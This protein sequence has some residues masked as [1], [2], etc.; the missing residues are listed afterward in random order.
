LSSAPQF[1]S[2][3]RPHGPRAVVRAPRGSRAGWKTLLAWIAGGLAALVF[4]VCLTVYVALHSRGVHRYVLRVSQEKATR[5]LGVKVS[6][7]D[8]GLHFSGISPVL[9]LYSLSIEG[10]PPLTSPPLAE[11]QRLHVAITVTSLLHRNWYV[12]DIDLERPVIRVQV[13]KNGNNNL[14]KPKT[15]N[16]KSSTN[17]FDLGVRHARIENGE[18]YYN[19]RKAVLSADLH[20]LNFAS[21]YDAALRT[22]SGTLGYRDGRLIVQNYAPVAHQLDAEFVAS[23]Q[24]FTLKQAALRSGNSKLLL[25]AV[26][27]D[28]SSPRI[29]AQYGVNLD[30]GEASRILR[31]DSLPRGLIRA[32]GKIN[33]ITAANRPFL[34]SIYVDGNLG[35]RQLVIQAGSVHQA[36]DDL[37]ASY[38]VENGNL[39][40]PDLRAHLLGGNLTASLV[41]RDL[42]GNSR[43]HLTAAL[44]N[45]SLKSAQ[46]LKNTQE[47]R[48]LGLSGV[49]N[50]TADAAWGKT[51]DDLVARG[52]AIIR[53]RIA[54]SSQA[55]PVPLDGAV[56]ARYDAR[57]KQIDMANSFLRTPETSLTL[58]G[59]VSSRSALQLVLEANDLHELETIA[60]AIRP[61][62]P[63]IGLYGRASMHATVTGTTDAPK[64]DSQFNATNLKVRGT[65]WRQLRANIQLDPSQINLQ[66]GELEAVNH[67]RVSFGLNAKLQK[68]SFTDTSPV[69]LSLNAVHIDMGDIMRGAGKQFPLSGT[70]AAAI[71]LHGS[72]QSPLGNGKITLTNAK[73]QDEV[74][75]SLS[76]EFNGSGDALVANLDAQIPAGGA[77]AKL[78]LRPRQKYFEGQLR[79]DGIHLD[80]LENVKQRN[81]PLRGVLNLNADGKG[82]FDNPGLNATLEVPQLDVRG[83]KISGLKLQTSVANHIG[84]FDLRS[85]VVHTSISSHG[86]VRLTDDFYADAK[87]DTQVIP[88]EP[89]VEAYAASQAGNI[90]GQ[91]EL[92]ATIRGPLKKKDQLEAHVTIPQLSVNYKDSIRIAAAGPIH[93]DSVRGTLEIPRGALRGTGTDLQFQGTVPLATNAAASILLQGSVDLNLAQIFDPDLASSGQIKFDINSYGRRSDPNVHGEI[94]VVNANFATGTVPLGL[95]GGNGVLTLLTDRVQISQFKGVLGGGNFTASGAV[96]YRPALHFDVALSGQDTRVLYNNIRGAFNSKLTLSGNMDAAQLSGRV[97]VEQMQ[98][99]PAF[100]LTDFMGDLGGGATTPPPIGGFQQALQLNVG[101]NST[102]GVNLVSRTMSLQAAANLRLTGTAAQPV[103]LGRVN[104][105]GGDLIFRGN[106]YV[107]QG[108]TLDFVN[109]SQTMPVV[110]LSANTTVQQY[111]VQMRFWG[112]IDHLHTNYSSD[113]A[114]PP[115]DII[116]LIAVGKTLEARGAEPSPPGNLAAEQF[117]ASQVSSQ[118]T[119]RLEKVSGLSQLSVDPLLGSNRAQSPGARITVQERVTGKIFVTFSTDTTSTQNSVMKIE[120]HETPRVSYS[121]TRDQNGG[122]G[123]DRRIHKEW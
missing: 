30:S 85:D 80:Q 86:T 119:N 36:V 89:L 17:L 98:F 24:T 107:L 120:Y 67:G 97:D 79:A 7:S 40:V 13:D 10:A 39:Q 28:Y 110:N 81:M 106:R 56:H 14:P 73:I 48:E 72:Q 111:N 25:R 31:N 100:D 108:G 122:F 71:S 123:F 99:T 58:S 104:I 116:S 41:T 87:L 62:Q 27:S 101:I 77:T 11:A 59:S 21:T 118:I 103:I 78:T 15:S 52:D 51:M 44:H 47:I 8:F 121:A 113:P 37:A 4:L 9:D 102:S 68:W 32:D 117:V 49:V 43:S 54:G 115:S 3:Y 61:G 6:L 95:Q 12:N 65:V 91:T 63:M 53:A 60:R 22:Y 2:D 70:L 29:D 64:V 33:Y 50:G 105:N 23:P 82:T 84:T 35:S 38:K 112:P 19:D 1:P 75:N 20:Q 93:A 83:Q 55:S 26:V 92:H 88:F 5:A 90:R 109:P 34:D 57:R 66:K 94:H 46:S 96:V 42:A 45:I 114:L 18:I 76:L 16:A 74:L 69:Q